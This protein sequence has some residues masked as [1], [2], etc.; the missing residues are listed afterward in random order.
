MGQFKE[1]NI[2]NQTDYF[3][4]DMSNVKN[5]HLNLLKIDMNSYK[6]I[7]IYYIGCITINKFGDCENIHSVNPLYLIIR[8]ATVHFREKNDEKYL[9]IDSTDKC[10]EVLC[11]SKSELKMLYG[12]KE[13][14]YKKNYTII[15][16]ILTMI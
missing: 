16:L 14:F 11:E 4:N 15:E 1:M 2:Q 8:P 6:D 13:M 3:F 12:E 7:N 9:T 5:F 10:E